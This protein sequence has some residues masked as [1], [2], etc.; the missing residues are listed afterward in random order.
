MSL[1]ESYLIYLLAGKDH[2]EIK[3]RIKDIEEQHFP[4]SDKQN[5]ID[6]FSFFGDETEIESIISE[7]CTYPIF[8]EKKLVKVYDFDKLDKKKLESYLNKPASTT[9]LILITS[10]EEKEL[11]KSII[12][13]VKAKGKLEY[14]KEKYASEAIS[15]LSRN[16]KQLDISF[17][18]EVLNYLLEQEESSVGNLSNIIDLIKDYCSDKKVVTVS[19]IA[20]IL[21]SS[22]IPSIFEFIDVLFNQDIPKSLRLFHQMIAETENYG[23]SLSMIYR[24]LKLIWQAKSLLNQNI[25]SSEVINLLGVHSFVG[26]K[27]IKQ[28]KIFSFPHLEKLFFNLA[29]LDFFVKS[30]EKSICSTQFEIFITRFIQKSYN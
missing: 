30:G 15:I 3:K 22:K 7:C 11:S 14:F 18:P 25:T 29:E 13:H 24:Q 27:I 8:S 12:D 21:V 5:N 6:V 23:Q 20:N 1:R 10:K 9:I 2:R 4:N 17:E 28:S 16:L 19:D 26:Q